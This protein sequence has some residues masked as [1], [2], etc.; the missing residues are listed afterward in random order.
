MLNTLHRGTSK[1]F[2]FI[3]FIINKIRGVESGTIIISQGAPSTINVNTGFTPT[4]VW[5]K[6]GDVSGI[7]VCHAQ[8]DHFDY[9]IVPHGF[10]IHVVLHSAE[11]KI[12]WIASKF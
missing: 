6:L 7:P 4:A 11:R 2:G 1:M 5:I 10:T 3:S 8:A 9:K 12:E